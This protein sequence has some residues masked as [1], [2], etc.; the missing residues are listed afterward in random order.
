MSDPAAAAVERTG[1][2]MRRRR[3]GRCGPILLCAACGKSINN[4][5]EGVVLWNA[6]VRDAPPTFAHVGAG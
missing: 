4:A 2:A 5:R 1:L 6:A 3:N